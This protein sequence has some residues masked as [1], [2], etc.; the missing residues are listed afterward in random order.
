MIMYTSGTTG[1]PKG[2]MSRHKNYMANTINMT[3][4]LRVDHEDVTFL[5]MPLY[6]N[7]GLWPTL[8][9]FY[10]GARIILQQRFEEKACLEAIEAERV[11]TFNLVPI[12]LL[13]LLEYP[14]LPKYDCQSLRLIFY[15]GAPMP[16]PVL[17]R[18]LQYFGKR[19]M[20]GLGLTE[21]S[22]G[23]TFLQKEDLYL[24][25]PE[26][27]V[28]RLG[29][30]GRDGMNVV[31]RIINEQGEDVR[32]GEVGE[33]IAKGDNITPGYWNLPEETAK[34]IREGW[35]YT[36]IWRPSMRSDLCM[37]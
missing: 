4:E 17:R 37:S 15:G 5:V 23:I 13:R 9:H 11:T 12:M 2:V 3:L 34:T 32:S 6:H 21:A 31:T 20:T 16:I 33:V 8:V 35:L 25:G 29:S 36:G 19:F 7:G 18:G 30:V 22:G 1:R 10:R 28:R 24:E 27:K 26:E 14:D